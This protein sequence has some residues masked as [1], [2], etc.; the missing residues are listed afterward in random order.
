[1]DQISNGSVDDITSWDD[2]KKYLQAHFSPRDETWEAR[3]KIKFIKQTGNLQTY[4]WEFA[5]VVLELPDMA[6]RDKVFN[7]IIRLKPWARNEVKRQK[8]KTLEESFVVVD[9]LVEHYDETS[10]ERKKK[11]D[12]PKEKRKDEA[13]K[14][15]EKTKK[16]PKCWIFV[17]PH[18]VKN[19]PSR[20]KVAAIAQSNAKKEEP[21]VGMMQIFGVATATEVVSRRDPERNSLE[22][23]RMKIGGMEVLTMVDSGAAHNFMSE[24]VARR[25]G[26][27]FVPVKAKMKMV[28]SPPDLVLG[29]V[30]KVDITLGEWTGKVDFTIV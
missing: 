25:I 7:F 2:M 18:M 8:I 30:E 26:L 13:S 15:D 28:N 9:R 21:S 14:S 24:D 12:K 19:F 3:M 20:P 11:S 23:V 4:Q 5:S 27:K 16:P 22:Y 17:E 10:D 29:V 6:E 1:M